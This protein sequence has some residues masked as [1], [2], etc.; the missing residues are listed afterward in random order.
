KLG[1]AMG[2]TH[3]LEEVKKIMHTPISGEITEREPSN[4]Y[5]IMQGGVPEVEEFISK[6]RK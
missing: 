1:W 2:Q 3:D 6:Y 4:G 5:L